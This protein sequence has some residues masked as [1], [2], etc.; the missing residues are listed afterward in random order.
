MSLLISTMVNW[1][2]YLTIDFWHFGSILM[3]KLKGN[4]L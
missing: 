1:K 3:E 4:I 2:D